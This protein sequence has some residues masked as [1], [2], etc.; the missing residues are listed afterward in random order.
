MID[1]PDLKAV[2]S[3]LERCATNPRFL[4]RFY[5]LFLEA[6]PAVREKFKDTNFQRQRRMV[7][8]S[9]HGVISFVRYGEAWPDPYLREVAETHSRRDLDIAPEL[10]ELWLQSLLQAVGEHDSQHTAAIHYAW[11][12]VM[13]EGIRFFTSRY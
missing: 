13:R 10:Y 11:Q 9:L 4:E 8:A 7:Q 6:S 5:D 2:E 1:E 12:R 3:S